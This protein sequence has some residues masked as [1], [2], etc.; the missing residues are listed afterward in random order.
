MANFWIDPIRQA[1]QRAQT[2]YRMRNYCTDRQK[3]TDLHHVFI[4]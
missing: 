3:H 2:S 4:L 1:E